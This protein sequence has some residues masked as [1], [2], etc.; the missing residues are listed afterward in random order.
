MLLIQIMEGL[1]KTPVTIVKR[2]TIKSNIIANNDPFITIHCRYIQL[3]V[4]I[5]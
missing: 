3:C 4:T 2:N 5:S 1:K